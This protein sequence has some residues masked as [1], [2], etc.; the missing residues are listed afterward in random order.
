MYD[1]FRLI[2][3]AGM[4]VNLP[5]VMHEGGAKSRLWR[6]II[7][8]VF[9]TPTVLTRSRTGAPFGDA[10]LAGV[11]TGLFKD[12]SMCKEWA[13]YV[14]WMDPIPENH[15]RYMEYFELYKNLYNHVKD[16]YRSLAALRG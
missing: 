11:A 14:D 5:I 16:D 7:T 3:Q 15:K 6:Q 8:D 12:Y 1:S 10:V 13:E 2:K 9:N 4:K